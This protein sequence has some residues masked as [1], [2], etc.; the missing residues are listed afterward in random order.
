MPAFNEVF[1]TPEK[2]IAAI[3]VAV[4]GRAPEGE[5]LEFW[6]NV[7]NQLLEQLG[8]ETTA[9]IVLAEEMIKAASQYPGYENIT[10]PAVLVEAVYQNVLGKTSYQDDDGDG[11]IDNEWWVQ[12]IAEGRATLGTVVY[13]ILKAAVEQYPDHPATKTLLNRV[14][15]ALY[16][17]QKI[18]TADING[19]G[20]IDEADFEVFKNIIQQVTDDPA[21]VEQA[22][23]EV[24]NFVNK[25]QEFTL[26]TQADEIIGTD[27]NDVINGVV[28]SLASENTLNPDDKIDGGAG[29][30]TLNLTVKGNFTGFSDNG[31]LKN[32][33][34]VNLVN[35][36]TIPRTFSAKGVEGVEKY[37]IDA[38]KATVNLSNLPDLNAEVYL[39]NQASGTFTI[40]YATDVTAGTD[41]EQVIGLENVGT[42]DD[43]NTDANEEKA[44]TITVNGIETLNLKVEGDN[45]VVFSADSATD[46]IASGNGNI[47]I[48]T[49]PTSLKTVDASQVNGKVDINVSN[50]TGITKLVTG[51][52][53]DIIRVDIADDVTVN[54]E[55]GGGEGTDVLQIDNSGAAKT[56]RF[57]QSGIET[58]K[59]NAVSGAVTFSALNT[60][61]LQKVIITDKA[62]ANV[63]VVDLGNVDISV[64]LNGPTGTNTLTL[65]NTGSSVID[66]TPSKTATA[67]NPDISKFNVTLANATAL[68]I[69]V[70]AKTDYQG[71]VTANKATSLTLSIEGSMGTA[72]GTPTVPT[73]N[74]GA[75]TS[76][77]ISKVENKSNLKLNAP[78]ATD[79]Q[80]TAAKDLNLDQAGTNLSSLQVLTINT[81]GLVDLGSANLTNLPKIAQ[82]TISGTG[83]VELPALGGATL[84]Y[85]ISITAS[86]LSTDAITVGGKNVSLNIG[87]I[88]T[89]ADVSIDAS[90]VIGAVNIGNINNTAT[91]GGDVTL[92]FN[93]TLGQVW[94][95]NIRGVNITIDAEK[96]LKGVDIDG[97]TFTIF[98]AGSLTLIGDMDAATG[99]NT[100]TITDSNQD[101]TIDLSKVTDPDNNFSNTVKITISGG[102]DT[103]K[104]SG[105]SIATEQIQSTAAFAAVDT[106]QDFESGTD[107]LKFDFTQTAGQASAFVSPNKIGTAF[108]NATKLQLLKFTKNNTGGKISAITT[109]PNALNGG[110]SNILTAKQWIMG[111]DIQFIDGAGSNDAYLKI[112]TVNGAWKTIAPNNVKITEG[113][114]GAAAK[115]ALIFY[116]TDDHLL[117]MYGISIKNAALDATLDTLKVLTSATLVKVT[118]TGGGSIAATDIVIY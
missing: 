33:E 89:L 7:Y 116:D 20:K 6:K 80:I 62:T 8:D 86:G 96:A 13:E 40:T 100:L 114:A 53:D 78:K 92:N 61:D 107:T 52:G 117:K 36:S 67:D 104:L 26:T 15:V 94:L 110:G 118:T 34:I 9:L 51:A 25:G 49:V 43:P 14:E 23:Q 32:V 24:D 60:Q 95:G 85:G 28:S 37:V 45:V 22:M 59:F 115:V 99:T 21:T 113:A 38:T 111:K 50:A 2:K 105:S 72:G 75:A 79:L 42:P 112:Q 98:K 66:V 29:T 65:D 101:N 108:L 88:D 39:K 16:V 46:L 30:D 12:A 69:N 63:N 103:V 10:D 35:D 27:K 97:K 83:S 18:Q 3:Y 54:A 74:V 58:I 64:E 48:N 19:D 17:A 47:K 106:V 82:I 56:V 68:T 109:L 90:G 55:I 5:G 93:G 44:V 11:M 81:D 71:T 76:V 84:D 70:G 57:T 31:Y 77:V 87:T 73:I 41:D 91:P 1:D 102:V 4:F